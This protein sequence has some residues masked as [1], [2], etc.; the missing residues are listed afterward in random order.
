MSRAMTDLQQLEASI[1]RQL[2]LAAKLGRVQA[3][4]ALADG[5]AAGGDP[6]TLLEG[7]L[8]YEKLVMAA[9]RDRRER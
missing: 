8:A 6:I 2:L 1:S 9:E 5:I 7:L 3:L 4:K